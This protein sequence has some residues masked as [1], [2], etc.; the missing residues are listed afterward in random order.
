M[1]RSMCVN[2]HGTWI[3]TGFSS[4]IISIV[5]LKAGIL[6]GQMRM[7]EGEIVQVCRT[8]FLQNIY[9][10]LKGLLSSNRQGANGIF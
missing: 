6:K 5:D 2:E 3:A 8:I 10:S 9:H 1:V 4:G 7:Q